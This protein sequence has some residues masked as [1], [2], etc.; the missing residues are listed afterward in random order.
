M[1]CS[2]G[3]KLYVSYVDRMGAVMVVGHLPGMH[4]VLFDP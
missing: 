1:V 3:R 4:E 2:W